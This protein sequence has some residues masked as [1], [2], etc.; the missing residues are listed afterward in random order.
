M[1]GC[2]RLLVGV[3]I[4]TGVSCGDSGSS[5]DNI[6]VPIAAVRVTVGDRAAPSGD[7][8]MAGQAISAFGIQLFEAIRASAPPGGNVAVSPASVAYAL[9]MLEPGAVGD[10]Q[11][12][13]RALLHIDDAAA[14][15]A[16]MNAL[17]QNLEA[18]VPTSFSP[19]DDPGEV[20]MRIANPSNRRTSRASGPATDQC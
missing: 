15:H 13:L 10:S 2:R 4:V 16:S 18:R 12:Q 1:T 20:V 11:A 19:S 3:L 14:Y 9:A 8:K 5:S 17:E 7:P 6:A